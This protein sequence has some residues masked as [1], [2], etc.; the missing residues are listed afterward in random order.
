MYISKDGDSSAEDYRNREGSE[1]G[2][3]QEEACALRER[4]SKVDG[5]RAQSDRRQS[6]EETH[7]REPGR[8]SQTDPSPVFSVGPLGRRRQQTSTQCGEE[9]QTQQTQNL[10]TV[11][12]MLWENS[13]ENI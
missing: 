11:P 4:A 2:R 12:L 1:A 10:A 3:R 5:I 9:T 8:T 13:Q 6:I 7:S